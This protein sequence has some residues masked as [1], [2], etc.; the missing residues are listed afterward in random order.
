[1]IETE[2]APRVNR[3]DPALRDAGW[4]VAGGSKVNREHSSA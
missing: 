1:M 4:G 2:A 3:V